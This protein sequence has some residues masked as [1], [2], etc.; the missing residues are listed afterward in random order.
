MKIRNK[1]LVALAILL[2]AYLVLEKMALP[3]NAP[4][5]PT[6]ENGSPQIQTSVSFYPLAYLVEQIA[7]KNAHL[8]TI[9]PAGMEPHDFE[10]SPTD[11][12]KIYGSKIFIFNGNGLEPWAE[13]IAG[14]VSKEQ[15]TS[16]IKLS[17]Y[18]ASITEPT[19]GA[20]PHFWLDPN[21]MSLAAD[22]ITQAF[23]DKDN[24]NHEINAF[25]E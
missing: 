17:D 6:T 8:I 25:V 24:T 5:R 2:A 10:P 3:G 22:K 13:K 14:D 7:G 19:I 11:I 9:T 4:T 20:D 18:L 21:N 1:I 16:V 23:V 12:A 15:N